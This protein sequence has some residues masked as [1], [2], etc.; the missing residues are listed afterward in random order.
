M[1]CDTCEMRYCLH[2]GDAMGTLVKWH[3]GK[4]CAEFLQEADNAKAAEERK[5]LEKAANEGC[6][7]TARM[8]AYRARADGHVQKACHMSVTLWFV[9]LPT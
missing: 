1:W 4:T 2:C 7:P 5:R 6:G 9:A 8:H 3:A